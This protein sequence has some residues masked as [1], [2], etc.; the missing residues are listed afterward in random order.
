[1]SAAL[2]LRNLLHSLV[3]QRRLGAGEILQ[4]IDGLLDDLRFVTE[5]TVATANSPSSDRLEKTGD[6]QVSDAHPATSMSSFRSGM[7]ESDQRGVAEPGVFNQAD[8]KQLAQKA[9]KNRLKIVK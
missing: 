1:M 9:G 4:I 2:A 3:V 5:P 6:F 8:I 7:T